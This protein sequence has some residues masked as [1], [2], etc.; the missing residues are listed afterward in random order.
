M[1][2]MPALSSRSTGLR[3]VMSQ[4][5]LKMCESGLRDKDLPGGL[6]VSSSRER[7]RV[8]SGM[9]HA[10]NDDSDSHDNVS[11]HWNEIQVPRSCPLYQWVHH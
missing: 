7:E 11:G 1:A 9:Q 4:D 10:A 5:M 2:D 8:L 6:K 3:L